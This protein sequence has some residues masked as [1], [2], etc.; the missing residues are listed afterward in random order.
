MNKVLKTFPDIKL[1]YDKQLHNKVSCDIYS[2]S[3][4]GCKSIIWF[5]YEEETPILYIF[6]YKNNNIVKTETDPDD[7]FYLLQ[8]K[9]PHLHQ[10]LNHI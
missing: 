5:T 6:H 4:R 2:I 3:P 8:Q 7:S 10:Q 9:M 1:S